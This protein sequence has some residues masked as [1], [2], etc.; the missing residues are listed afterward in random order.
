[1]APKRRGAPPDRGRDHLPVGR[2]RQAPR[3]PAGG[4]T[5]AGFLGHA[6]GGSLGWPF[7]T[8]PVAE[9]TVVIYNPTHD[10]WVSLSKNSTAL[11][12]INPLVVYGEIGIGISLILGLLTRFGA[13]MGAVMMALFFVAGWSFTNGIVEE[14]LTY[15]VVLLAIAGLGAGKY[16]GLDA[17][18]RE[19][20][21]RP[22]TTTGSAS[23]SCRAIRW[24]RRRS[25]CGQR[26]ALTSATADRPASLRA[27][28]RAVDGPPFRFRRAVP[29]ALNRSSV[30]NWSCGLYSASRG[31]PHIRPTAELPATRARSR[32]AA[33]VRTGRARLVRGLVRGADPGP[34]RRLGGDLRRSAH[35]DPRPDRQRQDAGRVPVVSR[36][37]RPRPVATGDPRATRRG[38]GPLRLAAQGARRT[39]SSG[40][41]ARR[42]PGSPWPPPGAAIRAAGD[43]GRLRTGDTTGRGA[44]R[45]RPPTAGHP[46][47]DARVALPPP[48]ERR[49][50]EPARRR[51]RDRRRGP[52][53]RRHE[54]WRSPR[55]QPRAAR[56][57]PAGRGAAAPADRAV[58]DAAARST[59]IARFL[60]G[61][62]PGRE[63]AI[64][65]AGTRKPLEL[66]VV[67]PGRG[68]GPARRAV[69]ARRA[70]RRSGG[71]PRGA[72]RA[73]GRRSTRG[74]SS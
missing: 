31:R 29:S 24:S 18:G 36:P 45:P 16:Y 28:R 66:S 51:A 39:T 12:I 72:G 7:V 62:G 48:D 70:A 71:R 50:R 55:A 65:D 40:T 57:T 46:D 32:S 41:S 11:A 8:T 42:W 52:R 73:S 10:L 2:S 53:D 68:H 13:I 30:R 37:A 20:G 17:V 5:A 25:Q 34:G 26:P 69:A 35:A 59:T 15:M 38:P 58:G 22:A 63:V 56:G 61:A 43:L 60:G 4:W 1:M 6:T 67:V 64:V 54:A 47:H 44:S 21:V 23:G 49:P 33:G 3:R 74:S 9:G 19:D 14:H 27:E